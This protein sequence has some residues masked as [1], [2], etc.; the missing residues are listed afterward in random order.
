[1]SETLYCDLDDL[2]AAHQEHDLISLTDDAGTGEI[3]EGIVDAARSKAN[4]EINPFL[5]QRYD[6]P[7]EAEEVPA[8]LKVIAVPVTLYHLYARRL[9]DKD[10]SLTILDRYKAAK[11]L[12]QLIK[13]G[14]ISLGCAE[15]RRAP[16]IYAL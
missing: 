1:L 15:K 10:I 5:A 6:L 4:A 16:G 12:L 2:K 8:L 13:S 14:G 11:D 9:D 7:F 3:D